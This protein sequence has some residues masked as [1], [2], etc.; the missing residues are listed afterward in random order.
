MAVFS[1]YLCGSVEFSQ[2]I[3]CT[4]CFV[5][6]SLRAMSSIDSYL[7]L[8]L[9]SRLYLHRLCIPSL[10]SLSWSVRMSILLSQSSRIPLPANMYSYPLAHGANVFSSSCTSHLHASPL[11]GRNSHRVYH[12]TFCVSCSSLPAT[13]VYSH[14]RALPARSFVFLVFF[15]FLLHLISSFCYLHMTYIRTY[16]HTYSLACRSFSHVKPCSTSV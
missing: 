15:C 10:S 12:G 14:T 5:L 6:S 8:C 7:T 1:G 3:Q 4:S 11:I 13:L 9:S 16:I 2:S